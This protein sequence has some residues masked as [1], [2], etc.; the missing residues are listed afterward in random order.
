M[1]SGTD[2]FSGGKKDASA[3]DKVSN[4]LSVTGTVLDVASLALPFLEP[5]AAAVSVAGAIDGTYQSVKDQEKQ[6]NQDKGNYQKNIVAQKVPPSLAGTGFLASAQ[7]DSHKL[8][9]G[10][11]SF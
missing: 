1:G 11:S 8:I 2:F 10:T 6:Q 9:G 5:V 3:G 7:T 4:A